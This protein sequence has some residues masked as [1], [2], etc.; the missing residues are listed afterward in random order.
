MQTLAAQSLARD[1]RR[2]EYGRLDTL[3]QRQGHPGRLEEH[4]LATLFAASYE[5]LVT[6]PLTPHTFTDYYYQLAQEDAAE[7]FI[8]YLLDNRCSPTLADL[9]SGIMLQRDQCANCGHV[10]APVNIE[11]QSL[12]IPIE[13]RHDDGHDALLLHDVQAALTTYLSGDSVA[14][15]DPCEGCGRTH[16]IH[17][18][19]LEPFVAPEVLFISLKRFKTIQRARGI[20]E[21]HYVQHPVQTPDTL[22]YG[23]DLYDLRSLV[24]HLGTSLD[25]GHYIA[26]A[27]HD[28]DNGKWWVYNDT[29][30]RLATD[31]ER[32]T[33][34]TFGHSGAMKSYIMLYEKRDRLA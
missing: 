16:Q 17:T 2:R 21:N 30:R 32:S 13:I 1:R 8:S 14:R 3:P 20:F 31:A 34:T 10:H 23:D 15:H 4:H 5:G 27:R 26:I 22:H 12:K 24:V 33:L 29:Q 25:S 6:K 19:P 18:R 7:F 9:C 11:H 28:T